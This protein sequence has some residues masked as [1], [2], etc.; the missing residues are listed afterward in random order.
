MIFGTLTLNN[1]CC[2]NE[3][4]NTLVKKKKKMVIDLRK[5]LL[6]IYIETKNNNMKFMM[7]SDVG[8]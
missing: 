8:K 5:K 2:R 1:C 3:T 7:I 4:V 6:K